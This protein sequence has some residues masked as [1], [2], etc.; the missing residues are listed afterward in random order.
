MH[1]SLNIRV[2]QGVNS[3]KQLSKYNANE[4]DYYLSAQ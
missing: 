2:P 1:F 3:F 4:H